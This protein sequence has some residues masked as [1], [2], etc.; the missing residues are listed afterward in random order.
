VKGE[1]YDYSVKQRKRP[2]PGI[3][4]EI[5]YSVLEYSGTLLKGYR[6]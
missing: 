2:K 5:K 4:G 6:N 3:C 1:G